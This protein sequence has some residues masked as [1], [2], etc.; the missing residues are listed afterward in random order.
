MRKVTFLDW[1]SE[2][3][4]TMMMMSKRNSNQ[5]RA[6]TYLRFER[7]NSLLLAK[8]SSST[9][10]NVVASPRALSVSRFW[11]SFLVALSSRTYTLYH[12]TQMWRKEGSLWDL[13]VRFF[14]T[15]VPRPVGLFCLEDGEISKRFVWL[16]RFTFALAKIF[17]HHPK[18]LWYLRHCFN[19][20]SLYYE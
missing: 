3:G 6:K 7:Q 12:T 13:C 8:V 9:T 16:C 19:D 4:K 2:H 1:I 10:K 17:W 15:L 18:Y 11:T 5:S 14:F 20:F